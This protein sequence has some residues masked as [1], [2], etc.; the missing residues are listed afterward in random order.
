MQLNSGRRM[1]SVLSMLKRR[2]FVACGLGLPM[3]A[4]L[5]QFRVEISGVG[6]NQVPIAVAKFRDED[7]AGQALAAIVRA[8]LERSGLFRNVDAPGTLDETSQ[9][10]MSEWRGRNPDALVAGSVSRLADGRFDV[11]LSC[12]TWSRATNWAARAMWWWQPTCAWRRT[13]SPTSC[14]KN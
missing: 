8:D 2:S 9:P 4:A 12:G 6:A 13:A 10:A 3:G 5:A 14:M 11:R 1:G 7:R